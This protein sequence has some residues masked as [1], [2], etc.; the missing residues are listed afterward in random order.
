[1]D[2][3]E[4]GLNFTILLVKFKSRCFLS[5]LPR[6]AFAEKLKLV[7]KDETIYYVADLAENK[8]PVFFKSTAI[9]ENSFVCEN[10]QHDFPKKIAYQ[11]D[12]N[13]I[14]ATVS[15][16]GKSFDYLFEKK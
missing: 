8:E 6:A 9:T 14:K 3:I 13:K 16:D 12:G 15:G 10:P 7:I 2:H 5:G 4:P 11:K 1:M